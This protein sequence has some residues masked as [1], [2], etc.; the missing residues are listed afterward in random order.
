M[1]LEPT[2]GLGPDGIEAVYSFGF[3]LYLVME[4]WWAWSFGAVWER[5][6][7]VGCE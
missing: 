6:G 1:S 7:L 4:T 2:V 3:A 5:G